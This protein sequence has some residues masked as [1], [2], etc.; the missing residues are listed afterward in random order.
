MYHTTSADGKEDSMQDFRRFLTL[1][2]LAVLPV[3]LAALLLGKWTLREAPLPTPPEASPEAVS[4]ADEKQSRTALPVHA[5]DSECDE[6]APPPAAAT[7]LWDESALLPVLVD[8]RLCTMKLSD[9]VFGALAAEMPALFSEEALKAQAVAIRTD[10]LY[11]LRQAYPHKDGASCTSPS[12]C[13]GYLDDDALRLRWGD[14]Y[15]AYSEKLRKAV[16]DTDGEILEYSGEPIFAAFHACSAGSTENSE[17]VWVSSL[18][19]LRSVS[20]PETAETVPNYYS[21]VTLSAEA[22][23]AIAAEALPA[24]NLNGVCRDWLTEAEWNESGRLSS[25]CV[26]GVPVSGSRLRSLLGLK[27]A[28]IRWSCTD[29]EIRFT[30]AGSGHGVGLSQYGAELMA[31]EGNDYPAI[32]LHYYPGTE[33]IRAT[34]HD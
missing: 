3:L 26:G 21:E 30:C 11:R 16:S 5:A 4:H 1:D 23:K 2:G 28:N 19:Y 18:P 31:Q 17:A 20:S 27:S 7:P 32:L 12:C 24:A 13:C 33:R 6:T 34:A 9:Y 25:V 22:L 29:D 15:E 8:G 10:A 14:S